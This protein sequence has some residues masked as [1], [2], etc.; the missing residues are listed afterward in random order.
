M[1]E[2]APRPRPGADAE[3]DGAVIERSRAA[4][5]CFA[6]LFDRH[7]GAIHRYVLRRLGQEVADDLVSETFLVAFR[8][9]GRYDTSR[10]DARP[11]L[12]GIVTRLIDGHRR[13]EARKYRALARTG[14]DPVVADLDEEVA[15]QVTAQ[16]TRR[17]LADA[18][19]RLAKGDRDVLF[20]FAWQELS[21]EQIAEAL[22]IPVGTVRSR[23][24]R[25]RRKVRESLY[26]T[27]TTHVLEEL[28]YG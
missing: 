9:R 24:N 28:S 11:W 20:L 17:D 1:A 2:A 21:Y 19:A 12:Y 27:E 13:A 18:F 5:D 6:I 22:A 8:K 10:S 16:S 25:A 3:N 15:S 23:L 26:D 7:A 4:P 14:V